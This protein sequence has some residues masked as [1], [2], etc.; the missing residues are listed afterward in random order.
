[1]SH[2]MQRFSI[3]AV[4]FFLMNEIEQNFRSLLTKDQS[5]SRSNLEYVGQQEAKLQA[6]LCHEMDDMV[7]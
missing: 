6:L 4:T 2:D 1:M 5:Q 3:L 7:V